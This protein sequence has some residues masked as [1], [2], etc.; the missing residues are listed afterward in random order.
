M[1]TLTNIA[2]LFHPKT[3]PNA[4]WKESVVAGLASHFAVNA[5]AASYFDGLSRAIEA[6]HDFRNAND[7]ADKT[8]RVNIVDFAVEPGR[9]INP[10]TIEIVHPDSSVPK[11]G[12]V[13]FMESMIEQCGE[14]FEGGMALLCN[15]NIMKSE[16]FDSQ[17]TVLPDDKLRDGVRYAYYTTFKPGREPKPPA[18]AAGDNDSEPA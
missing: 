2:L 10:P 14:Y 15:A 8:K 16:I 12:L 9:G 3:K 18:E 5:E 13:H 6:I 1:M 4:P 11:M 17:V 7:H